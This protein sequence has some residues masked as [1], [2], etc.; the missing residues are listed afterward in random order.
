M[1]ANLATFHISGKTP[2]VNEELKI[3]H[4]GWEMNSV[5]SLTRFVG[6]LLGSLAFPGFK[7]LSYC[8]T[9]ELLTDWDLILTDCRF[10]I[11]L[12]G[13]LEGKVLSA[14]QV[15]SQLL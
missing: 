13:S 4:W 12:R 9:C 3:S 5:A 11:C 8:N 2:V 6:I 1:G 10:L 15:S 7:F 14:L